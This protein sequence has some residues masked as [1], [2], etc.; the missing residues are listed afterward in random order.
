MEGDIR[1]EF[2]KAVITVQQGL[3]AIDLEIPS[4]QV[5]IL[6]EPG[7]PCDYLME[8]NSGSFTFLIPEASSGDVTVAGC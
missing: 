3:G 8:T 6:T 1:I 7:S 5:S 2:S 4:G